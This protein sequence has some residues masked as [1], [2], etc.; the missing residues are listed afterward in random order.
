V[1][2]TIFALGGGTWEEGVESY[3]DLIAPAAKNKTVSISEKSTETIDR[4]ILSATK[5]SQPKVLLIPTASEIRYDIDLLEDHFKRHYLDLGAARVESLRL[6]KDK[7]STKQIKQAISEADAIYV[8]G[9]NTFQLR[10]TWKRLG[11]DQLLREA[12]LAGTIMSGLSAGS[13]CWFRYGNSNSFYNDK[14]FRVTAMDWFPLLVCPHFDSEPVRQESLQKMMRRSPRT[15][16]LALDENAA[17]ELVSKR[18]ETL[19]RVHTYHSEAKAQKAYWHKNKYHLEPL[20]DD[21]DYHP[22]EELLQPCC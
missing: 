20:T 19:F 3:V 5:K 2:R 13:I 21:T 12:Y 15:M 17:I 22:L 14:P 7:P 8:S 10:R 18:N 9:G 6:L 4:A 16:G 1:E 11:V